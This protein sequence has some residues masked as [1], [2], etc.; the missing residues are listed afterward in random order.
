MKLF[1]EMNDLIKSLDE[2]KEKIKEANDAMGKLS[3]LQRENTAKII[4]MNN[5]LK[6][7]LPKRHPNYKKL[8]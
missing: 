1:E 4:D 7:L 6:K 2:A 3:E 8:N 5:E